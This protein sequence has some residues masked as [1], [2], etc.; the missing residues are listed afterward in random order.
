MS[1]PEPEYEFEAMWR[2]EM[3]EWSKIIEELDKRSFEQVITINSGIIK[4]LVSHSTKIKK[5]LIEVVL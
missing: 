1:E 5:R 4:E 2:R 3:Q